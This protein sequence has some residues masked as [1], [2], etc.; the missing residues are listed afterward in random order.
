[1][2][3]VWK[4]TIVFFLIILSFYSFSQA[5]KQDKTIRASI[6]Y[7]YFTGIE[8]TLKSISDYKPNF[9]K[10]VNQSNLL[11][12]SNFGQSKKNAIKHL[13]SRGNWRTILDPKIDL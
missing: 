1:M 8:T 7:G 5:T 13:D 4:K 11:L 2:E 12:F 6:V 3:L 10:E 9:N